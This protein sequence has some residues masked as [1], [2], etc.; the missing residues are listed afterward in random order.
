MA[1]LLVCVVLGGSCLPRKSGFETFAAFAP[2]SDRKSLIVLESRRMRSLTPKGV[3]RLF[4]EFSPPF[5]LKPPVTLVRHPKRSYFLLSGELFDLTGEKVR[6]L[7]NFKVERFADSP[8]ALFGKDGTLAYVAP[9]GRVRTESKNLRLSDAT[10]VHP[11]PGPDQLYSANYESLILFDVKKGKATANLPIE[12]PE[13]VIFSDHLASVAF[14]HNENQVSVY[15]TDLR[16]QLGRLTLGRDERIWSFDYSRGRIAVITWNP[17]AS[18][19]DGKLR[20]FEAPTMKELGKPR[21]TDGRSCFVLGD[22]IAHIRKD[23]VEWMRWPALSK[24]R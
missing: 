23:D 15:S 7:P 21:T 17:Q 13:H 24:P 10:G 6:P 14:T 9:D 16:R 8:L 12:S 3:P 18:T 1:L 4:R 2:A 19:P 11:G 22:W 20:L 5:D